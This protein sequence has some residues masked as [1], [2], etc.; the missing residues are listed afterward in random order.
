MYRG[1]A[2]NHPVALLGRLWVPWLA[3]ISSGCAA[4]GGRSMAAGALPGPSGLEYR[5]YV[6][7][8][9]SDLVSRVVFSQGAGAR[10]EREIPVGIMP[11]DVDGPHGVLVSP[12]GAFLYV[13]VAHGT[14]DG[15]LWALRAGEDSVV[16]RIPLGRFPATLS[17]SPDGRIL[18]VANFNLHGDP[19][20]SSVSVVFAPELT[21]LARITTCMTPHG[22]RVNA[23]GRSHYSVCTRSDQLVELSLATYA[24]SRRMSL[25]PGG[26]GTLPPEDVGASTPPDPAGPSCAPTWVTP[27]VAVRADR[28][29]YVTCSA[30]A[31]VLEV[32]SDAW[33]ITRRFPT[34]RGPYNMAMT[35]DGGRLI[36]TLR[37]GPGVSVI[38]LDSGE[39]EARVETT[40]S[41]T[42]GVVVSPD[43]RYAFVTNEAMGSTRGTLDV[44]DLSSL[45][46][47][48]SVELAHQ[49]GGIAFW[50]ADQVGEGPTPPG[51]G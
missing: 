13:T 50:R 45:E 47:A 48:A 14:P 31:A 26:E 7:N 4:P 3:L 40:E 29:L 23:S 16:G 22:G 17:S 33:R 11:A 32:E 5:V 21:E 34:G 27:G 43:G 46:I 10:I 18:V 30:R 6:A 12:D 8:E 51:D 38:D 39:E 35:P 1:G 24:V 25:R 49:P 15:W 42:H 19:A 41:F 44:L 20:P 9:S 37:G 2:R 36:V 28:Y